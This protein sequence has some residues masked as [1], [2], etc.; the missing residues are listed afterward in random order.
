MPTPAP[1]GEPKLLDQVRDLVRLK[2]Y[3]IRTEQ[4]YLG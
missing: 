2:H 3:N 4:A 1:R